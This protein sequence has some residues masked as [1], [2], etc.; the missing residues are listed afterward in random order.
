MSSPEENY[1]SPDDQNNF[2]SR[3]DQQ[4][5]N[6]EFSIQNRT[7]YYLSSSSYPTQASSNNEI[8]QS[9]NHSNNENQQNQPSINHSNNENQQNQS[10]INHSNNENQQNQSSNH[11][12]N[13]NQQNQ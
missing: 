11:S 7:S 5:E 6:A 2:S 9:S 10:S 4:S 12:N 8:H 1:A 13:E 3:P